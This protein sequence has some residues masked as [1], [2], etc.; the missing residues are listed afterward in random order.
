MLGLR[1][2][3]LRTTRG[4]SRSEF[5]HAVGI[6]PAELDAIE[7]GE[8]F[9]VDAGL[10]VRILDALNPKSATAFAAMTRLNKPLVFKAYNVGIGRT[11][12]LS[13]A[14][15]FSNYRACH[16]FMISETLAVI[17]QHESGDIS[18]HELRDFLLRRDRLGRLEFDS[19][20][21]HYAYLDVLVEEFPSANFIFTIRDCY[22][23]CDSVLNMLH[24]PSSGFSSPGT[25]DFKKLEP[26]CKDPETLRGELPRYLAPVFEFWSASNDLALRNLPAERSLILR[27]CDITKSL[28]K[29]AGF[30]GVSEGSLNE[31]EV[32]VHSVPR[33]INILK[34]MDPSLVEGIVHASCAPL[35]NR[36]FPGYTFNDYVAGMKP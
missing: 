32:H 28:S 31:R 18:R 3:S 16:Q 7:A 4:L 14:R 26:V 9:P 33:K 19:S 5:S 22:S 13:M 29:L 34:Q 30:L 25:F 12:T 1:I 8:I 27:T 11:G 6:L 20:G 21:H 10:L 24:L 15:I 35:M 36:F 2:Q 17:R 23:W